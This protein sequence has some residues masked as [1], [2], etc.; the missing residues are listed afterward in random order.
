METSIYEKKVL[1]Y[2]FAFGLKKIEFFTVDP[3]KGD[4]FFPLKAFQMKS[5]SQS[6]ELSKKFPSKFIP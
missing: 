2:F 1:F 4:K 3:L 6:L 5:H